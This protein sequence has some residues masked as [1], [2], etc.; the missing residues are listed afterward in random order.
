MELLGVR[1]WIFQCFSGVRSVRFWFE[2][3]KI[4]KT[5]PTFFISKIVLQIFPVFFSGDQLLGRAGQRN[6]GPVSAPY[7]PSILRLDCRAGQL[8][9]T[10]SIWLCQK[11]SI[12]GSTSISI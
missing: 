4:C 1:K 6:I 10:W 12:K 3:G 8:Y 7:Q 2:S 5:T 11:S 9:L